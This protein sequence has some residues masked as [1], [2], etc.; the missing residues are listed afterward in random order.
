MSSSNWLSSMSSDPM[1]LLAA[2]QSANRAQYAEY[3]I[4]QAATALSD[5]NNDNA[6]AAFKKAVA[7][8]PNNTTAYNYLGKIYLSQGKA[9]DSIKAYKEL[10]RIQSNISTKDTSTDAPTLESATISLGNA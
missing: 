9:E 7:L 5:G 10:V 2:N 3:A 4:A 1:G 6:I 8:D